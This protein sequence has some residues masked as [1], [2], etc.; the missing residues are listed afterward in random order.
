MLKTKVPTL[1]HAASELK[2]SKMMANQNVAAAKPRL[3]FSDL[4]KTPP[5]LEFSRLSSL[6]TKP[7]KQ[8][9]FSTNTL[10]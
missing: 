8:C 9:C 4:P 6:V 3:S 1:T 2:D 7:K 10:P 5:G